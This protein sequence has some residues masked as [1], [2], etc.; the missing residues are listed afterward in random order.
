MF[1]VFCVIRSIITKG[2]NRI[3]KLADVLEEAGVYVEA[4]E[5]ISRTRVL[6]I[7]AG[8]ISKVVCLIGNMSRVAQYHRGSN[9]ASS[10]AQR[11]RGT[12]PTTIKAVTTIDTAQNVTHDLSTQRVAHRN[13]L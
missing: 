13:N 10:V 5:F 11:G 3:I 9:L 2:T 7:L 12:L 4:C 8:A 1:D 6:A